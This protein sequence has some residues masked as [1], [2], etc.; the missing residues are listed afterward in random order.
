MKTFFRFLLRLL[1]RFRA[2]NLDVLKTPGPV[3]LIPNHTSWID[4]LFLWVHLEE[5]WKFVTS[6]VTAQS[7]WVHH[8]LMINHYTLPID[9]TSPYAVKRMA[10]FLKGGGRLVLFAEGR[11]SRTGRLMKLFEGT[12]FLIY[13]TKAKVI[14]A[15]LRGAGRLP[16]SPNPSPKKCFPKVTVHFSAV[17][18]PPAAEGISTGRART[19]LTAWLR[20]QMVRQYFEVEMALGARNVLAAVAETACE[21]PGM[22]VL[23][24]ASLQTLTYRKLM[25]GV[26]VL[27]EGLESVLGSGERVGEIGRAH[28]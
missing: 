20:D 11:L 1:F 27:A 13:K 28:V 6:S 23:E 12:G 5:D 3:L 26:D 4:W 10:E 17:L 8:K 19:L 16:F 18:A 21:R 22:M 7:S 24:D 9:T 15:N 2:Y 25:V 14:T